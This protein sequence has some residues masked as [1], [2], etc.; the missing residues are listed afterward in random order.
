MSVTAAV[1][2]PSVLWYATR[3]TGVVT[4][5]LLTLSVVLG[6]ANVRRTSTPTVPRFVF[7]ALHRNASL[8]ALAFLAVHIATSVLDTF[9]GIRLVNVVVPFTGTYRPVW[10][11]LGA[12]A[13]DLLIAVAITSVLRRRL[14]HRAW[15]ATHWI[16]YACWPI[17][18]VHGLGTGSDAKTTWMLTI[19]AACVIAVVLA[20][21]ARATY[22][23]SADRRP[24]HAGA[25]GTA[26]ALSAVI[27]LGLLIWLP[28]GPL[29]TGWA[30]RAGTPSTLLRTA[31][32]VALTSPASPGA[33][34]PA[35]FTAPVSGTVRQGPLNGGLYQVH[36]SL[37]ASGPKLTE[38]GIRIIGQPVDGGGVDMTASRVELGTASDPGKYRGQVTALQA[39][40]IGAT[41]SDSSGSRLQLAARL[42]IDPGSG[43]VSGSVTV[44]P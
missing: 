24:N 44:G 7:D 20:V 2:G 26:I 6:V 28:S 14:G 41:V 17:A 1:T 8:L 18:L 9:A 40:N 10:L 36:L 5:I 35:T 43:A 29:A 21:V 31:A 37:T 30:Q 42:Q 12:V 39:T 19:T 22:G 4:L 34:A 27:P 38:L 25:R 32:T 15:R 16:A 33:A 23:W 3:G 13:S 11:G